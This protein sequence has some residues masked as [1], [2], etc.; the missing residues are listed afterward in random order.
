[1]CCIVLAKW[2]Q[3]N[4]P[5]GMF[6]IVLGG[7]VK[8]AVSSGY[9]SPQ[10]LSN[11][12]TNLL[13]LDLAR[14]KRQIID[15]TIALINELKS[16]GQTAKV[17]LAAKAQDHALRKAAVL[18]AHRRCA[19][20][21]CTNMDGNREARIKVQKCGGCQVAFYCGAECQKADW[22]AGHKEMCK[23]LKSQG[24]KGREGY[25]GC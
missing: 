20:P 22:A 3:I 19:N 23:Q 6:A 17:K 8:L 4:S 16:V 15:T 18:A 5:Y 24:G 10:E 7:Y 2:V 11:I 12:A 21:T 9:G 14:G 13:T 1:M 25:G